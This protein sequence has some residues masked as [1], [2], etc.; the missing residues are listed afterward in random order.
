M[1]K[2]TNST[3]KMRKN[4]SSK[5]E[6]Q[7]HKWLERAGYISQ[8]SSGIFHQNTLMV[9]LLRNIENIISYHLEQINGNEVTLP[10]LQS[11][12]IWKESKRWNDFTNDANA[13]MLSTQSR[14]GHD[15]C[16]AATSEEAAVD[17]IK[18][19]NFS[20]KDFHNN[21]LI[22]QHSNKFRDELRSYG[23]LIR[24]KEFPTVKSFNK[25]FC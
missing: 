23:G 19:F 8:H 18:S 2:R 9:K 1:N 16:L 22:F 14:N 15:F 3:L 21:L 6:L 12:H 4:F 7:G 5:A 24:T 25:L 10:Q 13:E 20:K 11:D 17:F